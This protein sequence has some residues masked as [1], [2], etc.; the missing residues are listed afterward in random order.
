MLRPMPNGGNGQQEL[1]CSN[2]TYAGGMSALTPI[3][4][5]SFLIAVMRYPIGPVLSQAS[6]VLRPCKDPLTSTE[7][8]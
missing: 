5:P 3:S 7:T 1:R 6:I 8:G 4:K 2:Q